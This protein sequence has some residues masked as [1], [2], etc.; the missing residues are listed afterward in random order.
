MIIYPDDEF[1]F[2]NLCWLTIR[3]Q[4]KSNRSN[5]VLPSS[6]NCMWVVSTKHPNRSHGH[7]V[8]SCRIEQLPFVLFMS[9]VHAA[10]NFLY[11]LLCS[12]EFSAVLVESNYFTCKS[13]PI[14][15]DPTSIRDHVLRYLPLFHAS[16]QCKVTSITLTWSRSCM[17]NY[18][19]S[20]HD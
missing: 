14:R 2:D 5:T 10:G 9:L 20:I 11:K 17:L 19:T 15:S 18:Y 3:F 12:F 4:S 13:N 6:V 7:N 8:G 1:F 16:W